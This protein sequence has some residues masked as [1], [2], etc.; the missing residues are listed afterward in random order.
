MT[1]FNQ[2][3][4]VI[5]KFTY[6]LLQIKFNYRSIIGSSLAAR[7]RADRAFAAEKERNKRTMSAIGLTNVVT[8]NSPL[9]AGATSIATIVRFNGDSAGAARN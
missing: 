6:V 5:H 2:L 3:T 9:A 7:A 4:M 1:D 8:G